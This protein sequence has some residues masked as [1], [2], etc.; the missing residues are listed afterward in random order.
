MANKQ[1]RVGFYKFT[2]GLSVKILHD[3][4]V[5]CHQAVLKGTPLRY[6]LQPVIG[7]QSEETDENILIID[8]RVREPLEKHYALVPLPEVVVPKGVSSLILRLPQHLFLST[9]QL[10]ILN[11]INYGKL[12][13]RVDADIGH[14][15]P[16][17]SR[18][19]DCHGGNA[20]L[21]L[22]NMTPTEM[23]RLYTIITHY[24]WPGDLKHY[25]Q[26]NWELPVSVVENRV[27][28]V[29]A[30]AS[31]EKTTLNVPIASASAE[32]TTVNV[33]IAV[34][35]AKPDENI[36]SASKP[37]H[38]EVEAEKNYMKALIGAE[39]VVLMKKVGEKT[40]NVREDEDTGYSVQPLDA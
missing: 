29:N 17:A 3:T 23:G 36:K 1:L 13:V 27:V 28:D 16:G 31:I 5:G 9:V 39:K 10:A 40:E 30:A 7:A 19:R 21:V 38:P 2:S 14:E 25:I 18:I 35:T 24:I 26:C 12:F 34:P 8:E 20:R 37:S 6:I 32:K 22:K 15:Y 11:I 33:P 4:I